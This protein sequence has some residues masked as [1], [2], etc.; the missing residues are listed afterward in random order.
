M[1]TA[2]RR[3]LATLQRAG[4]GLGAIVHAGTGL[5]RVDVCQREGGEGG[6]E[7]PETPLVPD[8]NP[9]PVATEAW[10]WG[11]EPVQLCYA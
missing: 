4:G 7:Q 9:D 2:Q 10:L 1:L 5:L 3:G 6:K 8:A 11:M